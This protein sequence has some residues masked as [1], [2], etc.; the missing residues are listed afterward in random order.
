MDMAK[1]YEVFYGEY[2]GWTVKAPDGRS[3]KSFGRSDDDKD[4]AEK[5]AK[6]LNKKLKAIDDK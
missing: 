3:I 1:K 5:H 6:K 2:Y 4:A